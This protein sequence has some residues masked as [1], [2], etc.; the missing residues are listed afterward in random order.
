MIGHQHSANRNRAIVP[1]QFFFSHSKML[2]I[3]TDAQNVCAEA[4]DAAVCLICP[5][6][7]MRRS[8]P[9]PPDLPGAHGKTAAYPKRILPAARSSAQKKDSRCTSPL[10]FTDNADSPPALPDRTPDGVKT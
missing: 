9:D 7:P 1:K 4:H 5:V 10:P 3:Q 6:C 2:Q 8:A